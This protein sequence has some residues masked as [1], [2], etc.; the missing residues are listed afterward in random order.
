MIIMGGIKKLFAKLLRCV[1]LLVVSYSVSSFA[2]STHIQHVI[3][4]NTPFE[5]YYTV[6]PATEIPTNFSCHCEGMIAP[7]EEHFC[8]CFSQLEVVERRYHFDYMKN[9][10]P[11][12]RLSA[13]HAAKTDTLIIWT[14]DFDPYWD[15]LNV[16]AIS[17]PISDR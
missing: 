2:D 14:L 17:R 6:T 4:N 16:R 3:K 15:W 5:F 11:T 9:T 1:C 12:Y 13:T 10:S 8:N 7:N